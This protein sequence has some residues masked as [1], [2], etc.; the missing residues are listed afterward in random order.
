MTYYENNL[1]PE[2]RE[3]DFL[4]QLGP[5]STIGGMGLVLLFGGILALSSVLRFKDTVKASAMVRPVGE[6][7]LVQTAIGGSIEEITVAENQL[8]KVGQPLARLDDSRLQTTRSQLIG[9]LQQRKLQLVQVT[10]ELLEIDSQMAAES[11]LSDRAIAVAQAQVRNQQR[12]YQERQLTTQADMQE[13]LANLNL[14]TEELTRYQQLSNTGAIAKLQV[15]EKR[16]AV[17]SAMSKQNRAKAALHPINAEV[18]VAQE[19]LA[20]E[21]AKKE[22]TLA[23]LRQQRQ[24]LLQN[25]I[26]LQNQLYRTQKDLQQTETDLTRNV[27]RAPIAGTIL[28]LKLRNHNQVLQPGDTVAYIAPLKAPLVIKANVTANDIDKVKRGQ[29]VQMQVS[30]CPYPDYGTLSGTV[31][32]IAPDT[33]PTAANNSNASTTTTTQPGYEVTIQPHSLFVGKKEHQCHLQFG[34]S[35][36][37]NIIAREETV[38]QFLLR[39]ARLSTNL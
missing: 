3:E 28:E 27:V 37:A 15:A 39:K 21:K 38:M 6:L 7:K 20:Q 30:A 13:A 18:I 25:R 33:Q 31:S 19:Q 35:G 2:V 10:T 23:G 34:M 16:A 36:K 1:L 8:V 17:A 14:A 29:K 22:A 24:K 26:E 32:A 11:K 5:W 9:D 4:P 12:I